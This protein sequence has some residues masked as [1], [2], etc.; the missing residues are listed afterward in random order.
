MRGS[1]LTCS[2]REVKELG[3]IT[4]AA[5]PPWPPFGCRWLLGATECYMLQR[6]RTW[7][8]RDIASSTA[9]ASISSWLRP[10]RSQ[11]PDAAMAG[12]F[13]TRAFRDSSG[14]SKQKNGT[15]ATPYR[16]LGKGA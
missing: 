3:A 2:A 13:A 1:L 14:V 6:L 8:P 12:A 9:A 10:P 16:W 7:R 11:L 5:Q 15:L 4:T